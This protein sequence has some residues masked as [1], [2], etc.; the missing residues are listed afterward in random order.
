MLDGAEDRDQK[1]LWV[2]EPLGAVKAYEKGHKLRSFT[3]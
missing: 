2:W 3:A 1:P